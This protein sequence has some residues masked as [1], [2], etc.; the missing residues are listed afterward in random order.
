MPHCR[1]RR[2]ARLLLILLVL[3]AALA[4][5]TSNSPVRKASAFYPCEQCDTI[6]DTC[7]ANCYPCTAAQESKCEVNRNNCWAQCP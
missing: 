3:L 7:L 6:Y 2:P 4:A 5:P 1:A